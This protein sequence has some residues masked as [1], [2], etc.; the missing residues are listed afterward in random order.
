MVGYWKKKESLEYYE[1][2]NKET[3]VHSQTKKKKSLNV[4]YLGSQN[5]FELLSVLQRTRGSW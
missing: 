1:K 2:P 3:D 4:V 5:Y